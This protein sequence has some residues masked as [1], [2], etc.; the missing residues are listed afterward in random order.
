VLLLKIQIL[1]IISLGYGANYF[2]PN[3]S[4]L[5][6][7][8][9]A[10]D[11]LNIPDT[12][13]LIGIM[14]QFQKEVPDNPKTS[15]D[16]QFLINNH[17][18]YNHYY[19]SDNLRCEGFLADRPPHNLAY[20]QKQLEAVG[21]YYNNISYNHLSYSAGM[22]ANSSSLGNGYYTVVNP[23][24]YYAKSDQLLAKFFTES[25]ELAKSDIENYFV[26]KS[27]TPEDVVFIVFHAGL[28]QDFSYPSFDPTIYDL[29][30]AYID[31][32]MM[33]NIN[34]VEISGD[35]INAGILLPETQN[36]IYYDVVEDIFG[37]PDYG[38]EDLCDIQVG[39]TGIFAFLLGYALGLPEMF[40][41]T[42]GDPG[43]GYF[44][45]MDYGSN[46]G[47]GIIPAPPSPW[48]RSLPTP[49]WSNINKIKLIQ[50][51]ENDY[52]L[53]ALDID[54]QII[55]VDISENEY[56]LIE[57][58]NNWIENGVNI[59]SLRRKNKI[60]ENTLGHWFDSVVDGFPNDKIQ[61]DE[62]TQVITGFDHY[63]YGLPGSGILIWHINNPDSATY[64]IGPN[65]NLHHRYIQIEE[66]DGA[67]DIGTQSY[68]FFASDDPTL[69]THWDLWFLGNE[70]YK[71]ANSGMDAKV[72]FDNKS[73][74][75][76]RTTDG[77]ESF[78]YIEILSEVSD[79][80]L[81]RLKFSG[82]IEI[83]NL[84]DE[85]VQY[86]G[87]AVENNTGIIFYAKGDSIYRHSYLDGESA[88]EEYNA[89]LDKFAFTYVDSIHVDSV[90]IT[91][92]QY[93]WFDAIGT[94]HSEEKT[95]FGYIIDYDS[96][97]T[98]L[99][100]LISSDS[101]L[102]F[103]DIDLDGLDEII[104]IEDGNIIARN[105]NG[106]FVNG[107][108]ASG[109]FSGVP[110]IANILPSEYG[111][112][113]GKPEIVCR[114]GSNIVILSNRGERLRQ[115]SSYDIDQPLAMV[116]LWGEDTTMA[117]I[118]G[119]RLF[120]FDLDM[121]HSY[122]LNPR[123]QPSGFPLSTGK[124][125]DPSNRDLIR[126]KAYNYPNPITES[127]TTFRFYVANIEISEVQV[128]IYNA[129]GYLVKDDLSLD[130]DYITYNEFNEIN[131]DNIQ[132]DAGLYLAEI[133]PNVGQS[134]LVRLVVIK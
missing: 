111:K 133:K 31:Q 95:P 15:G 87:N 72:I 86:L 129:A 18:D 47:R 55:K 12:L 37:N 35:Y 88:L 23:M 85:P 62:E 22:I 132:V 108:P 63:D 20:F 57:N 49:A 112:D 56:F 71:Y 94:G 90:H 41:T 76:T 17:E 119:S 24:E 113:I 42:T 124:H 70:G 80:M 134:E 69:G 110:L 43:I 117:L 131:W 89:S 107:F 67:Q 128:K 6:R 100:S 54:N 114:E 78:I 45:L 8:K 97:E 1:L 102:S 34:P 122:W 126:T 83:I 91:D 105:S 121:D 51:I 118:D 120:L 14:T 84:S 66:A 106:T 58:R 13:R 60:S 75:N 10:S 123:S 92:N 53:N 33:G 115:L 30:S 26:G 28:S 3:V 103:G 5:S 19:N 4:T 82:D 64:H 116:P 101:S 21:N 46:N 2:I 29:K 73:S 38:T 11:N 93:F 39:L 50:G 104:T 52:T 81:I 109:D 77:A 96:P 36:I 27:F 98:V 74:P 32:E 65:S 59:D 7:S 125:F 40:D 9:E 99:I 61:I 79:S 44:G 16:G 48:T 130:R 25:L 68:A 127:K